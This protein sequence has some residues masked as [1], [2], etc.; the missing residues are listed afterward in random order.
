MQRRGVGPAVVR[1]DPDRDVLRIGLGVLDEDVEVAIAVEHA[2]IEQL[3]LRTLA[4]AALV[5]A[6]SSSRYG[7][8]AC[9]YL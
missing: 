9:G 3:V 6:R 5:L 1:G 4:G 2:G 8:A 7:N